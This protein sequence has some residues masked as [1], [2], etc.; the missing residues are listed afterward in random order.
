LRTIYFSAALQLLSSGILAA[1][2]SVVFQT[3]TPPSAGTATGGS[4]DQFHSVGTFFVLTAPVHIDSIGLAASSINAVSD[5][6]VADIFKVPD[7]STLPVLD[8]TTLVVT[9]RIQP[10][11][12]NAIVTGPAQAPTDRFANGV[13]LPAGTYVVSFNGTPGA[14]NLAISDGT[15]TAAPGD[16]QIESGPFCNNGA[17]YCTITSGMPSHFYFVVNGSAL[18]NSSVS[19]TS[20][21]PSTALPGGNGFTLTVNG[22]GFT[23][24]SVVYWD[25]TALATTFVSDTQLTAVVPAN[26]IAVAGKATVYVEPGSPAGVANVASFAIGPPGPSILSTDPATILSTS[27]SFTLTVNGTGFTSDSTVVWNGF[28]LPTAVVSAFQLAAVVPASLLTLGQVDLYVTS[29]AGTSPHFQQLS[30]PTPVLTSV[31]PNIVAVG[32][33]FTLTL[34]GSG[35]VNGATL[36]WNGMAQV[37]TTFVSDTELNANIPASLTQVAGA[38]SIAVQNPGSSASAAIPLV[39]EAAGTAISSAALAHFAVGSNFTTGITVINTGATSAAYSIS[40]FDDNGAPALVP[41][42]TGTS[43]YLSGNLPPFG[44]VYVEAGNPNLPLAS[45]WAQVKA[46]SSIVVQELF[47]STLNDTH[48]EA[49]VPETGGSKAFELP[50]DATQFADNTPLYTGIA[51][52]NLDGQN[53]AVVTCTARDGSGVVIPNGIVIPSIPAMGHWA[54]NE[55]PGLTGRRGTLDCVSTTTVAVVGLRFIGTDT[56]SS[57]PVILK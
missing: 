17:T 7:L 13:D 57:L 6:I 52:A 20:L 41:F 56:F 46:E 36:N 38:F 42:T 54:G 5:T 32:A 2:S 43:N 53:A 28:A 39:V 24:S 44:S 16:N 1:Q 26:L 8:S 50:F 3:T 35:F 15:S 34:S 51:I 49:T 33:A 47:R 55:F 4:I 19:I 48:Y 18:T 37:P 27:G 22:T 45:G 9:A 23:S 25:S 10:G 14:S 12:T 29:G 21:S 40:F 30:V 11:L 31:N